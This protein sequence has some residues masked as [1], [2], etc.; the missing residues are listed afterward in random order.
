MI[1]FQPEPWASFKY[2]AASLWPK[3]WEEVAIHKDKIK[4]NVDFRQFDLLDSAGQLVVIVGREEGAV[5]G[6]WVGFIRPHLHYADSLTAYTDVYFIDPD[7][8][9]PRA[10]LRLF[11]AVERELKRRGAQK[12]FTATKL[13]LDHSKLFRALGYTE[14]ERLFTKLLED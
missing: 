4:L 2:E 13:H 9:R 1:T 10:A 7:Y 11:Q 3:H 5:V 12:I 14:T 8:R 6:Y